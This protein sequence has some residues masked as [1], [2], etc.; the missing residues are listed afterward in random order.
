M[1]VQGAM[2]MACALHDIS[3]PS[4]NSPK[5][6]YPDDWDT[7]EHCALEHLMHTLQIFATGLANPHVKGQPAHAQITLGTETIDVLA[8]IGK[9]HEDCYEHVK[10][11]LPA[12]RR[13]VALVSRDH[14][15]NLW[16][17]RFRSILDTS[18]DAAHGE[19]KFTDPTSAV[20]QVGYRELLDAFQETATQNDMNGALHAAFG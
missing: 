4:N 11:I 6:R 12:S 14:N 17:K 15:N 13:P 9:S 3:G 5:E 7:D 19:R 8:V 10:N 1:A 2:S 16:N 20:R 18:T